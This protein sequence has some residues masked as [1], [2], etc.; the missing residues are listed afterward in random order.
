VEDPWIDVGTLAMNAT[1]KET[2][3]DDDA[4]SDEG[5]KRIST[6]HS[7][8]NTRRPVLGKK[9]AKDLK[10]KKVEDDDIA[11]AMDMI[12]N[13]RLQENEDRKLSRNLDAEAKARSAALEER[14]A[15][16]EEKSLGLEEK[17]VSN[18]E[19]Q[20]LVEEEGKLFFMDTSNMD[21]RIKE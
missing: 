2:I 3:I 7:V 16:N 4:P 10:G 9:A 17:K 6:P 14:M 11:K 15:E 1:G 5:K 8:A 20:R 18:D 12:A 13:A 19:H 21:E